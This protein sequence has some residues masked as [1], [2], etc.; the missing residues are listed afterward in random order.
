M[1]M[2]R[3]AFERIGR[4]DEA[5]EVVN[6]D[7]DCCLRSWRAGLSVVYTPHAQL[8]HHELASR[9]N[10]KDIFDSGHF[11][12]QWRT[13]YATGDPFFSTRLTKFADAYS[14]DTEPA[15]AICASRPL[16]GKDAIKRILAVKLDH[17][18]DLITALPA[19]RRLRRH[20][21]AARIDLLASGAAK[22]FLAGAECR[23]RLFGFGGCR[24]ATYALPR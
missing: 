21:P 9:A 18:G 17:I 2:R 3:E 1:L 5:N 22:A 14:P 23:V 7:V 15:R 20:F 16:V 6:N 8:I 19:L 13:L 10:I 12:E 4:F 24:Y 11:A